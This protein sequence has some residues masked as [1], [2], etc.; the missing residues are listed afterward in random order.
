MG[1]SMPVE[2]QSKGIMEISPNPANTL[3]NDR[4]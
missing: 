1:I 4:E 3:S 2:T